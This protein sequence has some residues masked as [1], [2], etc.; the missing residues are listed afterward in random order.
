M[1]MFLSLVDSAHITMFEVMPLSLQQ[2]TVS[3]EYPVDETLITVELDLSDVSNL[4]CNI[5]MASEDPNTSLASAQE[6]AGRAL[7][8]YVAYH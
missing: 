2:I 3:F 5:S 8:R 6:C 4:R 7:Q 1:K